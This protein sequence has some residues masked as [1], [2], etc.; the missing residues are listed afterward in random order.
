MVSFIFE[1]K[2]LYAP[3]SSPPDKMSDGVSSD[4]LDEEHLAAMNPPPK[5]KTICEKMIDLRDQMR[6]N[7][8]DPFA[9]LDTRRAFR[10]TMFGSLLDACDRYISA[11]KSHNCSETKGIGD[12]VSLLCAEIFTAQRACGYLC[13]DTVLIQ[14]WN[15]YFPEYPVD[16][17]SWGCSANIQI[18]RPKQGYPICVSW[19]VIDANK[20]SYG[21]PFD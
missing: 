20:W 21:W 5:E 11:Y 4:E 9:L 6:A 19:H 1:N 12:E 10:R 17:I 2:P 3:D 13:E 8:E 15:E 7:G 14:E 18:Y 16:G